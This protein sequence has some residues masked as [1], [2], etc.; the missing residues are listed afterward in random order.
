MAFHW[1]AL[2]FLGLPPYVK[3]NVPFFAIKLGNHIGVESVRLVGQSVM[4]LI[5]TRHFLLLNLNF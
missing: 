5:V 4:I 1:V 2:S 3:G